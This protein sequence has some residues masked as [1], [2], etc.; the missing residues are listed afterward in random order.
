MFSTSYL[1]GGL[2]ASDEDL[3]GDVPANLW[4]GDRAREPF[5][6][7]ETNL[8]FWNLKA[9]PAVISSSFASRASS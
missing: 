6:P 2:L 4:N 5:I 9:R 3:P 7:G 8:N 1:F